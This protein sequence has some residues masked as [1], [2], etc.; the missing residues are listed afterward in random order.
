MQYAKNSVDALISDH[1]ANDRFTYQEHL[2]T[3]CLIHPRS[4]RSGCFQAI[5]HTNSISLWNIGTVPITKLWDYPLADLNNFVDFS[6]FGPYVLSIPNRDHHF[7][8]LVL[9]K[10]KCHSFELKGNLRSQKFILGNGQLFVLST[11][12]R[13]FT[14]TV[15]NITDGRNLNE[16]SYDKPND[17]NTYYINSSYFVQTFKD[18]ATLLIYTVATNEF[19]W[20]ALD[21]PCLTGFLRNHNF[22]VH[23]PP[24]LFH[25]DLKECR[26]RN[27]CDDADCLRELIFWGKNRFDY[28]GITGS[29]FFFDKY[30]KTYD[31]ITFSLSKEH[32]IV[33]CQNYRTV[34]GV[35]TKLRKTIHYSQSIDSYEDD[36]LAVWK[37][38]I[39]GE[40]NYLLCLE[41]FRVAES[42]PKSRIRL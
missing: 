3:D 19:K 35:T 4:L 10:G 42:N 37:Q 24:H 13:G 27:R 34:L 23:N 5:V 28:I 22:F 14:L 17:E 16:L 38:P 9:H 6:I 7:D 21:L 15:I 25:I 31:Y 39:N 41:N 40:P 33:V 11:I 36:V 29:C 2:F 26:E 20:I 18:K 8:A 12:A 32:L 30:I 1:I